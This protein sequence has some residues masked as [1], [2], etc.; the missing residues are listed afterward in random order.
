[1]A[2]LEDREKSIKAMYDYLMHNPK[3]YAVCLSDDALGVMF[4][5]HDF[6]MF[7]YWFHKPELYPKV[8]FD[9]TGVTLEE[10]TEIAY[11]NYHGRWDELK[12]FLNLMEL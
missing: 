12:N 8:C 11:L 10:M 1:M 2:S 3:R 6:D 7:N 9:V 4:K 5:I